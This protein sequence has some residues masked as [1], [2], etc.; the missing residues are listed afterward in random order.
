MKASAAVIR[1]EP[2]GLICHC[3]ASISWEA[4]RGMIQT[5]PYEGGMQL[6]AEEDMVEPPI[7]DGVVL[8]GRAVREPGAG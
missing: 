4:K 2:A 7:V 3:P 1:V 6:M 8:S 5:N